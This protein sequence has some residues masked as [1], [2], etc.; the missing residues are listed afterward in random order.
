MTPATLH[1]YKVKNKILQT[2]HK[3][4]KLNTSLKLSFVNNLSVAS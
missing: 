1:S 4:T 2:K 3:E